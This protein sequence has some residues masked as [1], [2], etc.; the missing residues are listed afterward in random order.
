MKQ[1]FGI[2]GSYYGGGSYGGLFDS[3]GHASL[4]L[5]RFKTCLCELCI[6]FILV[7]EVCLL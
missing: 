7:W 5:D 1:C 2:S 4:L 6:I 3:L